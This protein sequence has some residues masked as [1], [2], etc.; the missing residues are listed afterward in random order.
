MTQATPAQKHLT[1]EQA[2]LVP[3]GFAGLLAAFLSAWAAI[4]FLMNWLRRE[5]FTPFVIYRLL[6]GVALL[7]YAF[8]SS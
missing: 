3:L 1:P 4:A 2:V 7:A 8:M 6:L 5:S